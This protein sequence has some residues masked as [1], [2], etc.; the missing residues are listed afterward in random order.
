MEFE[1]LKLRLGRVLEECGAD[2]KH[3]AVAHALNKLAQLG[4]DYRV[5]CVHCHSYNT[6]PAGSDRLCLEC[7]MYTYAPHRWTL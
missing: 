7:N 5:E 2:L 1:E 6:R 4:V 3:Y